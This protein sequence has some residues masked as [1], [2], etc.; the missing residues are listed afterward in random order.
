MFDQL[1]RILSQVKA[2]YADVRYELKTE[3][4][5]ACDGRELSLMTS[6]STAGYVLRVLRN[7]GLATI[8]FTKASDAEKAIQTAQENASLIGNRIK[9]PVQ[10]A[11][12]DPIKDTYHPQ[13]DIDPRQISIDEKLEL[14]RHYN[15]I[16]L[17]QS[18]VATTAMSYSD[19]TRERCFMSSE[20]SEIR[21]DL[22]TTRIL[23]TIISQEGAVTQAVRV[24]CGG[25]DGFVRV[26]NR[27][28]EFEEM[29]ALALNLLKATPINAGNYRVIL[30]Q[31]LAGVFT[32]EAFGHFSEADLI[33]DSPTMRAKMQ[34]GAKLGTDILNIKDDPTRLHQLGHYKYDD[35]GVPATATQLMKNGVLVGRLHSRRTA[36]TFGEPVSGH[37]IAEDFRFAPIIR[38]GCIFVEPGQSSFDDLCAALGDGLYLVNSTGGQTEGENFT[39]AAQYGYQVKGGKRTGMIRDINIS[40]NLYETLQQISAIGNDL[41]FVEA[42]RCGKGQFNV[43]SCFGAPHVVVDRVLIGGL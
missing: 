31:R 39:F 10:L 18:K 14:L 15:D 43:R 16:P 6:N 28:S 21:E 37:A 30:N 40:G 8:A 26:K 27:E 1:N 36:A 22:V 29:T 5:I 32:H 4:Q 33:E 17:Q 13:L 9:V 25:G 12:V 35:E 11:R 23:G 3:T 19:L 34:L 2:D 41:K 42:G 24:A 38:M 20:G 7:G